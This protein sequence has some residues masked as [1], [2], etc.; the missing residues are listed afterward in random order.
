M[1]LK[2]IIIL[3]V[4]SA[5]L[6]L[7][8]EIG[9]GPKSLCFGFNRSLHRAYEELPVGLLRA[10]AI[11]IFGK[12]IKSSDSFCLPQSHGFEALFEAAEKSGSKEYLLWINGMNW[13]YCLGFDAAGRMVIKAEG[14]S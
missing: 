3:L 8:L 5:F 14:H 7:G 13:Y 1:K 4:C 9:R 10:E 12:P 11:R 2:E 6:A